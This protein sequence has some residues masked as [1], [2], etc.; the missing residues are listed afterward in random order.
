MKKKMTGKQIKLILNIFSLSIFIFSYFYLYDHYV[1]KTEKAKKDIEAVK[2][3][4][5]VR[6]KKLSEEDSVRARIDEVNTQKQAIIDSFPS[7]IQDEDNFMFIEQ[8]EKAL[9]ITTSSV[10]TSEN[11]VFYNT[12]IPITGAEAGTEVATADTS[13]V[14][15]TPTE[16]PETT[17]NASQD[18]STAPQTS[19]N[20]DTET[21][22]A[23]TMTAT[24]N[25]LSMSFITDYNGLKDI[26]DYISNY[27]DHTI[28]D[29][30]SVSADSATGVLAGNLVLKRF[31]L[32]GT[33]K[34]YVEPEIDGIDIGTDN[35]FGADQK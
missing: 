13:A 28:I 2:L 31:A 10:T 19:G 6:E 25:S 30:I 1:E 32:S 24:V 12:I 35:I 27:P 11:T 29:S 16:G 5:Q 21:A 33:K 9:N 34:E 18:G 3:E 8:M 14:A 26:A 4:I 15:A 23:N 17:E 7:S 22:A 20:N